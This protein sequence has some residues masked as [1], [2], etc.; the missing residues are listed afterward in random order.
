MRAAVV[1][2]A[3]NV[4]INIIVADAARDIAPDGCILIDVE[5]M[6]CDMGWVYDPAANSFINPNPPP[7][8][9]APEEPVV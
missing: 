3:T 8:E 6:S 9:P 1:D 5:R 2:Q 4:V 7:P